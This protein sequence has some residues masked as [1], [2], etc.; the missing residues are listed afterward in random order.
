[1]YKEKERLFIFSLVSG[2]VLDIA[3]N[4]IF[5]WSN[6]VFLSCF[7]DLLSRLRY[8]NICS[9]YCDTF[10]KFLGVE[11]RF[12]FLLYFHGYSNS[13][14]SLDIILSVKDSS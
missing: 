10:Y 3:L 14:G 9:N 7:H 12:M 1:M 11:E 2:I 13:P 8:I 4:K 6:R 5:Y